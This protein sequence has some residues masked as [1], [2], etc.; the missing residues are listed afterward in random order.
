ME[1]R[2]LLRSEKSLTTRAAVT[3]R[4]SLFCDVT[5][6][7]LV[8]SHWRFGTT[9]LYHPL[10]PSSPRRMQYDESSFLELSVPGPGAFHTDAEVYSVRARALSLGVKR[11]GHEADHSSHCGVEVKNERKSA[12]PPSISL[13]GVKTDDFYLFHTRSPHVSNIS[14]R[15]NVAGTVLTS[16][17]QSDELFQRRA[18]AIFFY[19]CLLF[20]RREADIRLNKN[21]ATRST[22]QAWELC[23]KTRVLCC[24]IFCQAAA[25]PPRVC[26][27]K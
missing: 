10:G 8:V 24:L 23:S 15:W 11:L 14:Y 19:P 13:P 27:F 22:W 7:W 6:R 3:L 17:R 18:L 25:V 2:L 16:D 5:Q 4:S 9:S 12:S 21:A 26:H 20:W 1:R